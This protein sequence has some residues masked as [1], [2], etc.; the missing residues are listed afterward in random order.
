MNENKHAKKSQ[1]TDWHSADIVAS[2]RKADWSLRG[3]SVKHGLKPTT[4]ANAM[5]RPYPKGEKHI[6][7]AI[8]VKPWQIWPSRYNISIDEDGNSIGTP[9]RPRGPV[10]SKKYD[11]APKK[12]CNVKKKAAA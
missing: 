2:L 3:L 1:S 6:A 8:G 10:P 4:L 9:N 12:T 11:T 7:D 5:H